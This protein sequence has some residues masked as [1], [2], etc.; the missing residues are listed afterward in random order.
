MATQYFL[1]TAISS[2][3]VD[4]VNGQGITDIYLARWPVPVA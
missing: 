4:T 1:F 2:A 3:L